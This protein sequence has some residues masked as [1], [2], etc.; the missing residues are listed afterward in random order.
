MNASGRGPQVLFPLEENHMLLMQG[1][2]CIPFPSG[3]RCW[4]CN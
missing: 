3:P 1:H 4:L 2:V